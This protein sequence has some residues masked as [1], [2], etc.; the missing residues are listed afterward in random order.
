[1]LPPLSFD[2]D[3]IDRL[4]LRLRLSVCSGNRGKKDL[5]VASSAV[6]RRESERNKAV[7]PVLQLLFE[8]TSARRILSAHGLGLLPHL[9]NGAET[10]A[11]PGSAVIRCLTV[12]R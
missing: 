6:R 10:L 3:D 7:A 9:V 8:I 2:Y 4:R 1:M 12:P 11:K 5:C